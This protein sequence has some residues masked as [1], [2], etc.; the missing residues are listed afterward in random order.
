MTLVYVKGSERVK[1]I[2][3]PISRPVIDLDMINCPKANDVPR[4]EPQCFYPARHH[5][6]RH[7]TEL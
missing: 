5:T 7:I 4:V 1:Y 3:K 2:R 6:H